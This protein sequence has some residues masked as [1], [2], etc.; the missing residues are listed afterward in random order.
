MEDR[1]RP[2]RPHDALDGAPRACPGRLF[3][4]RRRKP[5]PFHGQAWAEALAQRPGS[6]VEAFDTGHWVM[7]AAPERFHALLRDWLLAP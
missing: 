5:F 4:D 2:R 6:R 3:I 7:V 1:R